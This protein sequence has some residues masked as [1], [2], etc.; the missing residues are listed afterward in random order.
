MLRHHLLSIATAA[1]RA[2]GG[3]AATA[4][5]LAALPVLPA[6]RD[7]SHDGRLLVVAAGKPSAAMI[8]GLLNAGL[9]PARG[10]I[11]TPFHDREAARQLEAELLG[12]LAPSAAG[13]WRFCFSGHP[14]PTAASVEAGE[15]ALALARGAAPDDHL[16][17]LL[18]GGASALFAAPADGLTLDDKMRATRALLGG[19]AAIHELNGVR[20][21]LSAVK[22]GRLAAAA[23]CQV[24]TLAISDVISPVDDD[25]SVIGSGPTV[26]DASTFGDALAAIDRLGVRAAMPAAVLGLLEAGAAGRPRRIAEAGRSASVARELSA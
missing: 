20:K 24:T 2:V 3:E 25:P 23:R 10:V 26:P 13:H 6:L 18:S 17:V 4:H 21:H 14:V 19:G 7:A 16:L 11:A 1:L 12:A 5:A 9:M 15:H 22:G 8:R